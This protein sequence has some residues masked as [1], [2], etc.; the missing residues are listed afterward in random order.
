MAP[1]R[2]SA[3]PPA[4][5]T[6]RTGWLSRYRRPARN[7]SGG[8]CAAVD[9]LAAMPDDLLYDAI[10]S[11]VFSDAAAVARC[12]GVC[13]RWSRVVAAREAAISRALPPPNDNEFLPHLALGFFHGGSHDD[14]SHRRRRLLA[15]AA[16]QPDPCFV[17]TASGSALLGSLSPRLPVGGGA[18]GLFHYA[19]PVASRRGRVVLELL[20]KARADGIALAVCNPMTGDVAVLPPLAGDDYPGHDYTCAV[21]TADDLDGDAPPGFFSLVLVYNRRGFTALRCYASGAAGRWGP[22]ARKPGAQISGHVLRGLGPAVV[23]RR[24]AYWPIIDAAALAARLNFAGGGAAVVDDVRVLPYRLRTSIPDWN[25]LGTTPDGKL[26]YVSAAVVGD[27]LGFLVET[28]EP[29]GGVSTAAGGVWATA[30]DIVLTQFTMSTTTEL[31][32][33]WLGER[34]GTLLFTVGRRG[35]GGNSGAFALNL[36]TRSVEKLADGVECNSWRNMFGYEMDSTALLASI[37][38]RFNSTDDKRTAG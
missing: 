13:R 29:A 31:K 37:T 12:A 25:L 1:P 26:S 17:P 5:H 36:G 14:G 22:E 20:S 7:R 3:S 33:R 23:L 30:D 35:G 16:Q 38:A 10:F 28:L 2:R 15:P 6:T 8:E 21:L 19:R 11:R 9:P 18:A 24:V 34:S 32:L 4:P 27:D